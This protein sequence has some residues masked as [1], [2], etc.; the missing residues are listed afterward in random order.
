M[1]PA[2]LVPNG[3]SASRVFEGARDGY[4]FKMGVAGL[5]YYPDHSP[6]PMLPPQDG[7]VTVVAD[8]PQRRCYYKVLGI[9]QDATDE[10]VRRAYHRNALEL[11]PDRSTADA[12]EAAAAFQELQAA[13]KLSRI[14]AL[15]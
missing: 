2:V 1:P 5:G 3:F 13:Y 12:A 4:V 15:L 11:H 6:E 9:A 14:H 8:K 10:D 7:H